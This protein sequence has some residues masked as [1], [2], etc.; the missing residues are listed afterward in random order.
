MLD[1][2]TKKG[3]VIIVLTLTHSNNFKVNAGRAG[4]NKSQRNDIPHA[5]RCGDS[6]HGIYVGEWMVSHCY[7]IDY[8]EKGLLV[9]KR[10]RYYYSLTA[11]TSL[12]F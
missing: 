2:L 9:T 5:P 3:P 11:G 8:S 10:T 12:G 7:R 1:H 6:D 4:G